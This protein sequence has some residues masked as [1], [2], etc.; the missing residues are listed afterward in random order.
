MKLI[1]QPD[2]GLA[3]D[4]SGAQRQAL[5]RLVVFRFDRTGWKALA[6]AVA[7]SSS[8]CSSPRTTA[9]EKRCFGPRQRLRGQRHHHQVGRQAS[10]TAR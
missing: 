4:E 8:G 3:A 7:A 9:V 10:I 2:D 5:D 6:A 1:A